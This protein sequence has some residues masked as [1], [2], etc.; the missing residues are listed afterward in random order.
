MPHA[1]FKVYTFQRRTVSDEQEAVRL[2]RRLNRRRRACYLRL[3]R[4]SLAV[5]ERLERWGSDEE[6]AESA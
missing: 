5:Q 6:R 4:C 3:M 2:F 1:D